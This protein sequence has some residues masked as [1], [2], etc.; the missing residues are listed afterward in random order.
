V[1][2]KNRVDFIGIGAQKCA[3]SWI[4]EQLILNDSICMPKKEPHFFSRDKYLDMGIEWFE[5]QF[6]ACGINSVKGEFSTSYLYT[7][8]AA[9]RIYENYPNVKLIVSLRDPAKRA[10]SNYLN[11]I[12]AGHVS[13]DVS[14]EKALINHPE[15]IEQGLYYK[16]LEE[17]L[18]Y[19]TNKQIHIVLFEDIISNPNQVLASIFN[20]L[21]VAYNMQSTYL[22]AK[23]VS[24]IPKNIFL[25][26]SMYRLAQFL[27]ND[28]TRLIYK[29]IKHTN[30]HKIIRNLNSYSQKPALNEKM[31]IE[32][33]KLFENDKQNLSS[34][35]NIDT[36]R[37]HF[38]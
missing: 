20:L 34:T 36:S 27:D 3:T 21:N 6:N 30:I 25:E 38:H 1:N 11:D 14:F 12:M 35:F 26:K 5:K 8:V 16:Q 29:F 28:N 7:K 19:F 13:K 23:N 31:Y 4:Y 32:L 2:L 9:K 18:K 17:Y 24:R 15:Y 22:T 10:F 37:W 33:E